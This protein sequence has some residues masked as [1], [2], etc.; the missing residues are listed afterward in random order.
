VKFGCA[1][2][3][4]SGSG[5][6]ATVTF[7]LAG[8]D[9]TALNIEHAVLDNAVLTGATAICD[10]CAAQSGSINV[11]GG[12]ASGDKGLG[13][14]P[15]P[16]AVDNSNPPPVGGVPVASNPGGSAGGA[17]SGAG[18]PGAAGPSSTGTGSTS[19]N[20]A[21]GTIAGS[22]TTSGNTSGAAN[23]SSGSGV[24]GAAVGK[25]GYGPQPQHNNDRR[26]ALFAASLM[27]IAGAGMLA[28]ASRRRARPVPSVHQ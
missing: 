23:G 15:P 20:G 17:T 25:F 9:H 11:T 19:G 2:G 10:P 24:S 22:G 13:T 14:P 5:T 1:T 26:N 18:S 21:T 12:A 6:V 3:S 16:P 7:H 8:G 4:A 28:A 27:A